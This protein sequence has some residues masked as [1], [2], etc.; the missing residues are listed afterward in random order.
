MKHIKQEAL[1]CPQSPMLQKGY[2][3]AENILKIAGTAKGIWDTGKTIYSGLQA[4]APYA[5]AAASA[6]SLL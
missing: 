5:R 3:M 4:A 2:A 6:I 1:N